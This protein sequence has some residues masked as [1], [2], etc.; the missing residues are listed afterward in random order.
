MGEA[1]I[2]SLWV[3]CVP[4]HDEPAKRCVLR[5]W[6][7][8]RSANLAAPFDGK[9]DAGLIKF[10]S[11]PRLSLSMFIPKNVWT[12]RSTVNI[13]VRGVLSFLR[14]GP[15]MR[16]RACSCD[17]W[18]LHSQ[19]TGYTEVHGRP[20]KPWYTALRHYTLGEIGIVVFY[21]DLH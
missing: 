6:T 4:C 9:R 8:P 2:S 13:R 14:R 17:H 18:I 16:R 12:Q 11:L 10:F 5:W 20:W 1:Q 7:K 3:D 19:L 15:M 21:L